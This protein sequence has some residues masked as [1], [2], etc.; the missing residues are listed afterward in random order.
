MPRVPRLQV[1]GLFHIG[2]GSVSSR[3]LFYD[4]LARELFF[5]LMTRAFERYSLNVASYCL[6]S[7]HYHLLVRTTEPDLS[8][9]LQW[10]NGCFGAR[11]NQ[12]EG[13]RGHVF[14]ARF[15]SRRILSDAD[16]LA[17][18]RY[19]ARN[20]VEAGLCRDAADW[21]WSSYAVLVRGFRRP[22]FLDPSPIVG[23][24]GGDE[25]AAIERLRGLVED[26]VLVPT[27]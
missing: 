9:S 23:V 18:T 12:I 2:A 1:P 25:R 4:D 3:A 11:L 27:T 14:G 22:P 19:I 10:L 16:L 6:L 8:R 17:T 26:L 7:T 15:W 24:F 13:D 21:R 20:P 5:R